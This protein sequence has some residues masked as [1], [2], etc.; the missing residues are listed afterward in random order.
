MRAAHSRK[1]RAKRVRDRPRTARRIARSADHARA[2]A[3]TMDKV[4]NRV[5]CRTVNR[6][7]TQIHTYMFNVLGIKVTHDLD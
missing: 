4:Q 5:L 6:K 2:G 3:E 1:A 7:Y